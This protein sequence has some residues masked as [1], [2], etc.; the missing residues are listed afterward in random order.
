MVVWARVVA[1]EVTEVDSS[2]TLK[3]EPP[4]WQSEYGVRQNRSKGDTMIF[5]PVQLEG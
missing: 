3:A 4:G 1:S 5:L 2:Y